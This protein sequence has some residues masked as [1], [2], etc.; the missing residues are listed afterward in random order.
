MGG[1]TVPGCGAAGDGVAKQPLGP[2][3]LR[4]LVAGVAFQ[5]QGE[6]EAVGGVHRLHHVAGDVR[7]QAGAEHRGGDDVELVVAYHPGEHLGAAA[8]QPGAVAS[9]R[10]EP[11]DVVD[12]LHGEQVDLGLAQGAGAEPVAEEAAHRAEQVAVGRRVQGRAVEAVDDAPAAQDG[13]VEGAAVVGD[14]QRAAVEQLEQGEQER[15]FL[16]GVSEQ[17][18]V[19]LHAGAP[20]QAD[21]DQE[22]HHAAAAQAQGLDVEDGDGRAHGRARAAH[23]AGAAG[24]GPPD[25]A[26]QL[27]R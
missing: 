22:G 26:E 7:R 1:A 20:L 15:G 18:L 3:L 19:Q 16:A 8:A 25:Q 14:Q 5:V 2:P 27:L 12:P 23:A 11:G 6:P 10:L 17:E 13:D 9:R 21:A 24:L 4:R